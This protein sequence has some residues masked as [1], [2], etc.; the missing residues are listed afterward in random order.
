MLLVIHECTAYNIL[1]GLNILLQKYEIEL[2]SPF[3][4]AITNLTSIS[5]SIKFKF[6]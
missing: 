3:L 2:H 5:V 6:T 4:F 1:D